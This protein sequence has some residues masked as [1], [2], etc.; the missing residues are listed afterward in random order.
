MPETDS[1][2]EAAPGADPPDPAGSTKPR[3][4][5]LVTLFVVTI[6]SIV[7]G[8]Q[9]EPPGAALASP[10]ML[11]FLLGFCGL[12]TLMLGGFSFA[13][14][15]FVVLA[16]TGAKHRLR[17]AAAT[18]ACALAVTLACVLAVAWPRAVHEAA[19]GH[20]APVAAEAPRP[21]AVITIF[22][23]PPSRASNSR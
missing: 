10:E 18:F 11:Q 23:A 9:A 16:P 1:I 6:L 20:A 12:S 17:Y 3:N 8:V 15:H 4:A 21:Q 14:L 19:A 22:S 13:L 2:A 7:N 5:L